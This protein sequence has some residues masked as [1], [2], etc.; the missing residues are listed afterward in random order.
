MKTTRKTWVAKRTE[1]NIE[2]TS[3]RK[4]GKQS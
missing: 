3:L 1:I 4:D 2:E